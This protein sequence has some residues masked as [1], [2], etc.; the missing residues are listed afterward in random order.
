MCL[1]QRALKNR[2]DGHLRLETLTE[3]PPGL[4]RREWQVRRVNYCNA[5]HWQCGERSNGHENHHRTIKPE[6]RTAVDVD[7]DVDKI[8]LKAR[9]TIDLGPPKTAYKLGHARQT[10]QFPCRVAV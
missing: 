3:I 7:V 6:G 1:L 5:R 8:M 2:D 4:R 9:P 10:G